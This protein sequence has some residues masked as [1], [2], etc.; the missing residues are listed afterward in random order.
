MSFN[1]ILRLENTPLIEN[2]SK[3]NQI[4]PRNAGNSTVSE[5]QSDLQEIY[6][7][8]FKVL[9]S[10]ITPSKYVS[11]FVPRTNGNLLFPCLPSSSTFESSWESIHEFG[12]IKLP[13]PSGMYIA[14]D[15]PGIG[16]R[17]KHKSDIT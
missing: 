14:I 6:E 4:C 9:P 8:T 10:K 2:R 16:L 15:S 5:T 12:G 1:V 13:S 17:A 7:G 11:F 3:F